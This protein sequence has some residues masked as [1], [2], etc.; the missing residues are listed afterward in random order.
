MSLGE[1]DLPSSPTIIPEMPTSTQR[2]L[3]AVEMALN[4][5]LG[6]SGPPAP[7]VEQLPLAPLDGHSRRPGPD[8]SEYRRLVAFAAP[9]AA[10]P[11]SGGAS[12]P[13][14][15]PGPGAV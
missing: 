9:D 4:G 13:G 14:G 8:G 10:T 2:E 15:L 5:P 7:T 11:R 3:T 6:P 1:L 12:D